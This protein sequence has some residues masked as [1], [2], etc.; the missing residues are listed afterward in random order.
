MAMESKV[1]IY[2]VCCQLPGQAVHKGN[3]MI[4]IA[5]QQAK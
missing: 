2:R 5:Q 1:S 4:K 3:H